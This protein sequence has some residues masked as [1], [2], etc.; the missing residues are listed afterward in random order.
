MKERI[1]VIVKKPGCVSILWDIENTLQAL[2]NL[3]EGY[4]EAVTVATNLAIICNEE[5]AIKNLPF[6]CEMLGHKFY[7]TLVFVGVDGEDFTDVP[8]TIDEFR[9]IFGGRS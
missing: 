6:N 3:V 2:Q 9:R 1:N 5:G 8:L 4:I 7:G